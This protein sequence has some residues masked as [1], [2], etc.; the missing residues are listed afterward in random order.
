MKIY[1]SAYTEM[2]ETYGY[3]CET[4]KKKL[5]EVF[6]QANVIIKSREVE[7]DSLSNS[8]S[9]TDEEFDKLYNEI[10]KGERD[11]IYS[12]NHIPQK[13]AYSSGHGAVQI[14]GIAKLVIY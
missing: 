9:V 2:E 5:K 4:F 13:S 12:L 3:A 7:L 11:K 1:E 6:A 8:P 14:K 10:H